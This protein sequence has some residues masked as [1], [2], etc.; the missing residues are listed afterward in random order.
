ML[1]TMQPSST[2]TTTA[3]DMQ[4]AVARRQLMRS[5]DGGGAGC[6]ARCN[7]AADAPPLQL[8]CRWQWREGSSCGAATE[9][10][11]DAWHDATKQQTH[12]HCS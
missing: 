5:G 9:V 3:A 2:R 1:G 8:T 11:M 7:Q 12:Y 6:L 10:A 4:V